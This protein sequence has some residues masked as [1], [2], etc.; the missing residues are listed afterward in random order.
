MMK[1]LLL[2]AAVGIGLATLAFG[3]QAHSDRSRDRG[4]WFDGHHRSA[5]HV[6]GHRHKHAY[7]A[8][9]RKVMKMKGMK[10]KGMKMEGDTKGKAPEKAKAKAGDTKGKAGDGKGK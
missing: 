6:R 4:C 10:M 2:G 8:H 5:Q 3:A 9:H 7:R 1:K